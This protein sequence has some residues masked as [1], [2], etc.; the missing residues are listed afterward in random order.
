M[1]ADGQGRFVAF[2]IAPGQAPERPHA[3]PL[4]DA[5]PRVPKWV[6]GDRGYASHAFR[7]HIRDRGG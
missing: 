4:L 2:R 6:V 5:R 3:V 1:I 7:Q